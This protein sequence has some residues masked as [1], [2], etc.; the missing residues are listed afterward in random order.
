MTEPRDLSA[1]ER[2]RF[3]NLLRVAAESPYAGER[4]NALA[5]AERLAARCGM[6]VEEAAG[7]PARAPVH[8]VD[9]ARRA[10][11][12]EA[13]RAIM[14]NE[15]HLRA[16]KARWEQAMKEAIARGLDAA[17][18]RGPDGD[19]RGRREWRS[20]HPKSRDRFT[21]ARVLLAETALPFR[22][23]ASITG[24]DVY[25][26]VGLKLKMRTAA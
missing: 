2:V 23:V 16:E 24:L 9:A 25:Q 1:R 21:F 22:E 5:A 12:A 13:A 19:P 18:R 14:V 8:A 17:D 26:V 15:S 11:W 6:T 4:A 7:S 20:T 10:R 3:R